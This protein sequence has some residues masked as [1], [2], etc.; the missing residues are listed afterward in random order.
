M[1]IQ[2]AKNELKQQ[3]D[4]ISKV[5]ERIGEEFTKAVESIKTCHG[6]IIVCGM[7]KTGIIGRKIAAT[8]SSTGTTSIFLHAAEGIHGDLGIIRKEDLIIA[9]SYSGNTS[10]LVSLIPFFKFQKNKVIAL[11][12]NLTSKLANNSDIVL[13]C[14]VPK[15][16]EQF[17]LVPTA[18]TT[19]CLAMGD[20]LA[21]A[22]M[23]ENDFAVSDYA[24]LHPGGTIG[25]KILLKVKDLMHTGSKIPK[26]LIISDLRNVIMDMTTF[27]LGCTVIVDNDDNILGFFSDGDLRRILQRDK[28]FFEYEIDEVMT[29][30]PKSVTE[31]MLA[32]DALNFMEENKITMLPVAKDSK[33]VGLLHMHDLI[34]AGLI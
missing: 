24:L 29:K 26:T 31:E 20:A 13:D 34:D 4:A 30:N 11:T 15:D 2:I 25:K 17:G 18:S 8:L 14:S 19:V 3:A 16:Y 27:G 6:K 22:L 1:N 28:N 9:I 23:K 32:I 12:G 33:V 21:V 7:G 5:A 10:E